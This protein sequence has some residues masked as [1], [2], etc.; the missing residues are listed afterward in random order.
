MPARAD[1][2]T[3]GTCGGHAGGA[4]FTGHVERSRGEEH[5]LRRKVGDGGILGVREEKR[6]TQGTLGRGCQRAQSDVER[7]GAEKK[8][9]DSITGGSPAIIDD[10]EW[11][12]LLMNVGPD[13]KMGLE[14]VTN[15]P[16]VPCYRI[17]SLTCRHLFIRLLMVYMLNHLFDDLCV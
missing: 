6:K 11:K 4:T 5:R 14:H 3:G 12:R 16:Y 9:A 8:T 17:R 1:P 7:K 13:C 15:R 2:Q 10:E